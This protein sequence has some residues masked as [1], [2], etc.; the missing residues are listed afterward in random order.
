MGIAFAL[1]LGWVGVHRFVLGQWYWGLVHIFLFIAGAALVEST[2]FEFLAIPWFS[3]SAMAAYYTAFRW[4]RMSDGAFADRYLE[5]VEEDVDAGGKYLR[6]TVADHPRAISRR[7][8]RKLLAEARQRYDDFDLQGAADRY[9]E[10]LELDLADGDARVYAARCYSLLEDADAAYR[11]LRRAVQLQATNLDLVAEDAGFA[12]LRTR[13]D[14]EARRRA[15][16]APVTLDV[17]EDD[18]PAAGEPAALPPPGDNILDRLEQL[19]RLRDRGLLDDEEFAR[20][21]RRLLR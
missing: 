17:P 5:L 14:Y 12:W 20:E 19:G 21:K 8:R 9:E 2:P 3:F 10:A 4:I 11:H 13:P 6:G 16:Y 7:A 18:L 15:G 1:F